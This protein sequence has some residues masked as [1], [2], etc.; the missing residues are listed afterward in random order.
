MTT[1]RFKSGLLIALCVIT[2][3]SATPTDGSGATGSPGNGAPHMSIQFD[4]TEEPG[5]VAVVLEIFLLL[6]VLSLA[7]AILVMLTSFTRIVIVLSF[8]RQALGTQQM[9]PNPVVIGLAM[10]QIGRAHV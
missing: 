10:F 3:I 2:L 9:P 4:R 1:D 8:L 7:P 6:T 5:R